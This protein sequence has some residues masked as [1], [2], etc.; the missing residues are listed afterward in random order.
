M[1]VY[2]S[3]WWYMYLLNKVNK[4]KVMCYLCYKTST[5]KKHRDTDLC[6]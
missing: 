6:R 2:L 3:S 4:N 1:Y 5:N